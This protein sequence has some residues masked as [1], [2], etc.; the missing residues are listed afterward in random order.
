MKT[1][2]GISILCLVVVAGCG[3]K[4]SLNKGLP[5]PQERIDRIEVFSLPVAVNLDNIPGSDGVR[6]Q[7][8]LFRY[9]NPKPVIGSGTLEIF[10]F[11]RRLDASSVHTVQPFHVWQ[12]SSEDARE[13]LGQSMIGWNYR[14]ELK[15][16]SPPPKSNLITL[17]VCYKGKGMEPVY[18]SPLVITVN[19]TS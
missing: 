2:L 13:F 14:M 18:S 7:L 8:Y 12:F 15:W 10:L 17:V 19:Q 11:D 9:D 4:A 16:G 1:Y 5:R 6:L 3:P